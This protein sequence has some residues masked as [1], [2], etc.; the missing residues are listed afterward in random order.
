MGAS[1]T[2]Q[3]RQATNEQQDQSPDLDP[4]FLGVKKQK[5]RKREFSESCDLEEKERLE[6]ENLHTPKRLF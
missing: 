5:R 3:A 4:Q 1:H 6:E 2:S